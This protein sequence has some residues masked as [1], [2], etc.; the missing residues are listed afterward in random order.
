MRVECSETLVFSMPYAQALRR[1][2]TVLSGAGLQVAF[3][4]D[5]AGSIFHSTGVQLAKSALLGVVCPYQL[6]EACVADP[7]AAVFLPLHMIVTERGNETEVRLLAP[8]ALRT[9]GITIAVCLPVYRT[10]HR[11]MDALGMVGIQ[12]AGMKQRLE[13]PIGGEEDREGDVPR[14]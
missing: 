7:G 4:V 3:E 9:A 1:I 10:L 2:R 13:M 5:M 11:I 6:L 12:S 8:E 14:L